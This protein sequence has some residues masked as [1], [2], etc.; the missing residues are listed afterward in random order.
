MRKSILKVFKKLYILPIIPCMNSS[1]I[2]CQGADSTAVEVDLKV[3]L[4]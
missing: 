2:M 1:V 3:M 4:R